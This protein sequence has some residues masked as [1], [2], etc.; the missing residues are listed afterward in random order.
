MVIYLDE[1]LSEYVADALNLLN[2]GYFDDVEVH[3][4][5]KVFKQGVP[6]EVLIPKIG[7]KKGYLI[8]RDFQIQ[9]TRLQF[10]LLSKNGV[11]AFF[12]KLPKG[13][14]RHWELVKLLINHWEEIIDSV[15]TGKRFAYRIHIRGK[16]EKI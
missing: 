4:T 3:S 8:T 16:M 1:N 6:D 10:D 13:M 15:R 14:S 11:G 12:I 9:K 5:K 2:K 7:E